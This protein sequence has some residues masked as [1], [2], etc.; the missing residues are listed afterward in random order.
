MWTPPAFWNHPANDS[1]S[2]SLSRTKEIEIAEIAEIG[3]E[4]GID[5]DLESKILYFPMWCY[6]G[7]CFM[8]QFCERGQHRQ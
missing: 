3:V 8:V 2:R 4:E 7:N 1:S 6:G 5:L